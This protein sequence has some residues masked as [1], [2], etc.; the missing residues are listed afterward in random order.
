MDV[1]R[2]NENKFLGAIIDDTLSWKSHKK[3][4]YINFLVLD[5]KSLYILYS[6][7]I[8]PYLKIIAQRFGAI[9]INANYNHYLCCKKRAI[10]IIH[11]TGYR[12]H[13]NSLF[14]KSNTSKCIYV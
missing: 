8:L 5:H 1:E 2:V 12:D 11:K 7:L 9:L 3:H 4:T 6:T 14:V 13:T 10:W